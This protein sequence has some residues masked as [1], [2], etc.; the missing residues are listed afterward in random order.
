MKN[1]ISTRLTTDT[2]Y[3]F[4]L[5]G[6]VLKGE[7]KVPQFQRNFIW[8]EDQALELLDSIANGYPIGSLLLWRTKEKLS[9]ERNIGDF[10]LPKTDDMSPVNYVLDGQQRLTVIFSCLGASETDEGFCAGYD[11]EKEVFIE[12]KPGETELSTFN[13]RKIFKTTDLLNYRAAIQTLPDHTKLQSRLDDIIAA[14]TTYRIPVVVLKELK[15]DEVCPIFERINSSGTRLSTYDLMVAATWNQ[16]FDL[17]ERVSDVLQELQSK[18]YS[19]ADRSTILKIFSAIHLG[20]IKEKTLKSL[21][22]LGTP[23][24][25]ALIAESRESIKRS[26]DFLSTTFGVR[27][28]DFLSYEAILI[29]LSFVY[30]NK[31]EFNQAE[32]N[33]IKKWFWR[34]SFGERYKVGG[35]HF[36]SNDLSKVKDFILSGVGDE[37]DFGSILKPADWSKISFRSNVSRPRALI[38]AMAER[39]PRNLT[40]GVAIDTESALSAFNKKEY[41]HFYPR[42]HVKSVYPGEDSNV[43]G[44][45]IFITANSNKVILDRSPSLYVPEIVTNLGDQSD[46]VFSS[47]LLPLPGQFD[48]KNST[49]SQF[50]AARGNMLTDY[51][52]SLVK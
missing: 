7:I 2:S 17:N 50:L 6:D 43:L 49:F 47:N 27:S 46:A 36:V 12:Y 4:Q 29:I 33:R 26:V 28:W 32:A 24:M 3:L 9:A 5:I 41:H 18:G 15:I 23:E 20:S 40:N 39:G 11:L 8:G 25:D 38:L 31:K 14:F 45:I 44:N 52:Q 34:C 22:D 48:Y 35:E 19:E 13:L 30:H 16:G 21:R 42:A 37:S 10:H 51:T 1:D